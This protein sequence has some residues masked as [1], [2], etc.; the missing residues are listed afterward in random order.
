MFVVATNHGRGKA[1]GVP[2]EQR[3]AYVYTVREGKVSEMQ[4]W[5]DR[6]AALKAA[7]LSE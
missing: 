3:V 7:G 1:S 6:G 5:S 4:V 2:V